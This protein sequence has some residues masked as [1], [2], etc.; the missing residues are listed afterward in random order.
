MKSITIHKQVLKYTG[1]IEGLLEGKVP[2]IINGDYG[3]DHAALGCSHV[4]KLRNENILV[5]NIKLTDPIHFKLSVDNE[6]YNLTVTAKSKVKL[7]VTL[8]TESG[9]LILRNV[10]FLV[11]DQPMSEV[12]LSWPLLLS[13]GFNLEE[14]LRR[15]KSHC[16]EVDMSNISFELNLEELTNGSLS[17]LLLEGLEIESTPNFSE[18]DYKKLSDSDIDF[19]HSE[20]LD[21][22]VG[23]HYIDDIETHLHRMVNEAVQNGLPI[24]FRR[25]LKELVFNNRNTFWSQAWK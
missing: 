6:E 14:H 19:Q 17:S 24:K 10:E 16:S 2:V 20:L 15:I 9:P 23:Q 13:L 7:N 25:Q 1:K 11:M 8:N 3:A 5:P 21:V 12:L 18:M 4:E 22:C